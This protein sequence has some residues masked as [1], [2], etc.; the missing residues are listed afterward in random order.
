MQNVPSP[1]YESELRLVLERGD[2]E[3]LREFTH[4]HNQIPDE[5]YQQEQ[6]FWEVLLHKLICNRIDMMGMHD[7]SREWL[8]RHGYTTDLGGF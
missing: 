7:A 3:A 2:W 1:E 4:K 6:H 8:E 5:I